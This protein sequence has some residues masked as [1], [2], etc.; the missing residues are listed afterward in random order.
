M[1]KGSLLSKEWED[2]IILW[3][4]AGT[5]EAKKFEGSKIMQRALHLDKHRDELVSYLRL[6]GYGVEEEMSADK[7]RQV[8]LSES[9]VV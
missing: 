6:L 9:G 3:V 1:A 7:I 4:L 8:V 5:S 2:A